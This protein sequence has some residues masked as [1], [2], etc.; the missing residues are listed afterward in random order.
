MLQAKSKE[1]RLVTLATLTKLE[2]NKLKQVKFYCPA[3]NQRVIMKAGSI[4]IPHFAHQSIQKCPAHEGGEGLYHEKGKLLLYQWLKKQNIHVELEVYLPEIN[5]RPDLLL[6]LN[7]KIIAIE[8]Q[9]ARVAIEQIRERNNGYRK[10]GIIPIWILGATLLKRKMSYQLQLD[11]FSLQFTHQFSPTYPLTLFYFC[12]IT[13]QFA[14]VRNIYLTSLDKAIG[15][16]Y[17]QRLNSMSFI[18]IFQKELL[19]SSHLY[20][21][22]RKE[23]ERFRMRQPKRLYGKELAWAKWLYEKGTHREHL[24]SIIYLPTVSQYLMNSAPWDW[25]SRL[26][27]DILCN[28]PLG[29]QISLKSCERIVRQQMQDSN[30]FPLIYTGKNPII[31]Y[32]ML[33]SELNILTKRTPHSF[34]IINPIDFY[35]NVEEALTG[36]KIIMDQLVKQ[37]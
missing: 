17:I 10:A 15:K 34:L 12:P 28:K 26:C 36:D 25:Q 4:V 8:Y 21:L 20:Q 24:P 13:N 1:G 19:K 35:K 30:S 5:Q 32:L 37:N 9:C 11:Q 22:W 27:I 3:C 2:I 31:E 14:S 18:D 7:T 33:L 16:F 23:K 6:R 29:T